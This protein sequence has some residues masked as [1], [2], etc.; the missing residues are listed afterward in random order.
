MTTIQ[1]EVSNPP[2]ELRLFLDEMAVS[3]RLWV[4]EF[5]HHLYSSDR[6]MAEVATDAQFAGLDEEKLDHAFQELAAE[7]EEHPFLCGLLPA[8]EGPGSALDNYL[9][10]LSSHEPGLGMYALLHQLADDMVTYRNL[11][12]LPEARFILRYQALLRRLL[13]LLNDD[14]PVT[15]LYPLSKLALE[16]FDEEFREWTSRQGREIAR[17]QGLSSDFKESVA[18]RLAEESLFNP[19]RSVRLRAIMVLQRIVDEVS[20]DG[21]SFLERLYQRVVRG[22]RNRQQR[23]LPK[24]LPFVLEQLP[25]IEVSLLENGGV[26]AVS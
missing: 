19:Y 11:S 8:L 16:R 2:S 9:D 24:R 5:F 25:G 1:S 21:R 3:E 12:D 23:I 7:A 26:D 4:M 18:R 13:E 10:A 6:S 17:D 22:C 20:D 15:G 14:N